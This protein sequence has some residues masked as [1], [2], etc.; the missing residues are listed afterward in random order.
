MTVLVTAAVAV[1]LSCY[2]VA[3][4]L[5]FVRLVRGPAAQDR[6]L[7]L[8]F[9]YINGMLIVLVL[10]VRYGSS[11]YFESA[12]LIALVGFVSSAALAKFLLRG[13]VIE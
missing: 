9:I 13:E 8:D 2:A 3:I 4:A 6:V 12:L 5:A 7:A 11:M 10:G 1:A